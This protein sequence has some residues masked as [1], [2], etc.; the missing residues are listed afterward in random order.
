MLRPN[1]P[2]RCPSPTPQLA[3]F[4]ILENRASPRICLLGDHFSEASLSQARPHESLSILGPSSFLDILLS[5]YTTKLQPSTRL[6]LDLLT[7]IVSLTSYETN[8]QACTL[9]GQ[10][11]HPP[12]HPVAVYPSTN[13]ESVLHLATALSL[14]KDKMTPPPQPTTFTFTKLPAEYAA[15]PL[16]PILSSYS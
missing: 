2:V 8:K 9:P 13:Y 5:Y 11:Y 6:A 3:L 10:L 1:S 12:R 4:Y 15:F 14:H 7:G 16:F